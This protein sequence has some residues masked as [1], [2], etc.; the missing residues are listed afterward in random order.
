MT[1]PP[2][3]HKGDAVVLRST[4]E[5]GR[6]ER[7]AILD[8]G[9]QWYRVRFVKRVDNVVEDDLDPLDDSD[10]SLEKLAICGR[11]GKVQ[12]FRCAL[13]AERITQKNRST[14]YSFRAQ[15]I[16]FEPYQYKPL[17]KILDSPDRR[18]LIADEVGLGKTIEAGLILTELE[19]RRSIDTVLVVCP[20]RLREKW[21]EELN[22]KFDQEFDIFDRR[23][24]IEYIERL[25]QN[26]R[27]GR[28]RA[29]I[30]MQT[31]RNEDVRELLAAEVG[32]L[33]VVIVDEA[34]HA[35]NPYTKTA[36][37]L[38]EL[39]QMGDCVLLLTAT[40]LH[41]GSRDLFTL[42]HALRPTEFRDPEVFDR[43][44]RHH[45]GVHEA[46]MLVRT[47]TTDGLEQ[48][49]ERLR[50]VF[51]AGIMPGVRDPLAVQVIEELKSAP[52]D[53]TGWIELSRKIE[54]LHPLAS[55]VTRT[56]KRDVQENAPM[57]RAGVHRCQWTAEE[58]EAYQTL[59]AGAGSHGWI[60]EQM[61]FGQIQ[62][63]RQAASCIPAAIGSHYATAKSDDD[64]VELSDILVSDI[65][66]G[67]AVATTQPSVAMMTGWSG[68]DS[69]FDKLLEIL[70]LVWQEEP[71]AKVLIF[72]FFVGTATYLTNRLTE[73]GHPSLRI[74]GDVRSDPRRP[75]L[76]ERGRRMRQFHD[77][78]S[79][80]V[81]VS[82]EVGSEG[83]DFQFCHHLVNY[84]L[85]WNPM[86]VEQRIGA[87]TVMVRNPKS[88]ASTT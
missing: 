72:T 65:E 2:L 24:M 57:R 74:A 87:S 40:P 28:L 31:L 43:E 5:M 81:L 48:A 83:L 18:L 73:K 66:S 47:R 53:C 63:A 6:V 79:I 75:E 8:A 80:K 76:D 58:D 4:R 42:L 82:T 27:R 23:S 51:I 13:V 14:V 37:M 69:K 33:D 67:R 85:P 56:R 60:R 29:I 49:A 32:H 70:E 12:A 46:E 44:L 39:G 41:L 62:K 20:S 88:S 19:A 25:R 52:E 54:D 86:V 50:R 61:N 7:D 36:E 1:S 59:V 26:P 22:R 35:R 10:E 64:A 17:L 45:A 77:D 16:L 68:Q 3:F 55:I 71:E 84:D 34:H 30:S 11:W 9:E 15:R 38:E 78:P 21:R